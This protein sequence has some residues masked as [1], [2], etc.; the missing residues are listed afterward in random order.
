[1]MTGKQPHELLTKSFGLTEVLAL[2]GYERTLLLS[3]DHTNFYKLREGYG[4]V[5]TYI[6]GIAFA[7]N[8]LNDDYQLLEQLRRLPPHRSD[9]PQFMFFHLMSVHGLGIKHAEHRLWHPSKTLYGTF[10]AALT[11]EVIDAGKN[12]YDNGVRQADWV[13]SEIIAELTRRGILNSD[14][15]MLI[16][17]DHA[18]SLG[19]HGIKTHSDSV[20]ESVIRIP[21]MWVGSAPLYASLSTPAIQADFAPTLLS[22]LKLPIP[23]HWTGVSLQSAPQ[24]RR[25]F[26]A[27]LPA[28]A[29]LDYDGEKRTKFVRDFKARSTQVFDLAADPREQSPRV[30][31]N[32][33]PKE[34]DAMDA[35]I[36]RGYGSARR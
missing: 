28:A 10:S 25:T 1:L 21:W 4:S 16:T 29:V 13:I 17:S 27:Q 3:G 14:S 9:R 33:S 34:A 23:E 36:R 11:P 8:A 20:Y 2:A 22:A 32:A 6:D 35:L 18:E 19:D 15:I 24:L 12:S 5:D 26:H 30:V 31:I 7:K